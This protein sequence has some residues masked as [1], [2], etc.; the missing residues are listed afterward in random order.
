[1]SDNDGVNIGKGDGDGD[2]MEICW[3]V[4]ATTCWAAV[5]RT[6]GNGTVGGVEIGGVMCVLETC[7]AIDAICCEIWARIA[8]DCCW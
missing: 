2:G 6:E 4:D 7:A 5:D 8:T 1:M 3:T